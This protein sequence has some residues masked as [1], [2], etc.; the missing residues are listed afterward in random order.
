[1]LS[2][3]VKP[4]KKATRVTKIDATHYVVEVTARPEKGKANEAVL[5][6]LAKYLTIP[7]SRL[8]ILSGATSHNKIVDITIDH[9]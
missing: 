6:A 2:I 7:V 9:K 4:G 1:M 3:V 5:K 8:R